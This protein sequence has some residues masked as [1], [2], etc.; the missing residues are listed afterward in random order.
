MRLNAVKHRDDCAEGRDLGQ[1]E[2]DE[3]HAAL[4]YVDAQVGVNARQDEARHK[5]REQKSKHSHN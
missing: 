2:I 3:D 1:G 5:G 4:H